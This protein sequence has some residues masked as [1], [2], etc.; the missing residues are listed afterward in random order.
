MSWRTR[1]TCREWS[2]METVLV[3]Q[4]EWSPLWTVQFE[5]YIETVNRPTT[6]HRIIVDPEA[7]F[8]IDGDRKFSRGKS[9]EACNR[10]KSRRDIVRKGCLTCH[11]VG[12]KDRRAG[13]LLQLRSS[14]QILWHKLQKSFATSMYL[15]SRSPRHHRC[16]AV[17]GHPQMPLVI[18][19]WRFA[20]FHIV[21]TCMRAETYA[22]CDRWANIG[23]WHFCV[24]GCCRSEEKSSAVAAGLLR[25]SILVMA[26]HRQ[27]MP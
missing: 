8:D 20:F 6:K 24:K 13:V 21:L 16:R 17:G 25:E 3:R 12:V 1:K 14:E 10:S 19:L 26:S 27:K 11:K 2:V 4:L 7:H 23:V 5:Y 22:S 18:R 9:K 15:L